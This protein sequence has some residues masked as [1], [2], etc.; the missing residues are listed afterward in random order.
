[1]LRCVEAVRIHSNKRQRLREALAER[2]SQK[3]RR[4]LARII[5]RRGAFGIQQT[6]D[7]KYIVVARGATNLGTRYSTV[8]CDMVSVPE[9]AT[10]VSFTDEFGLGCQCVTSKWCK[11]LHNSNTKLT[12]S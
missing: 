9:Q 8:V 12:R 2:S 11:N 5:L 3:T 4:N 7:L 6:V 10:V 1:M